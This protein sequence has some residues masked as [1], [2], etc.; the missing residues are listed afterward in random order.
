M[1]LEKNKHQLQY[2][3]GLALSLDPAL[4]PEG[5]S[6]DLYNVYLYKGTIK[7]SPGYRYF[8]EQDTALASDL[9]EPILHLAPYYE[10]EEFQYHLVFT[11]TGLYQLTDVEY[12]VLDNTVAYDDVY[13]ITT[14]RWLN[15]TFIATLAED[16]SYW[17]ADGTGVVTP[18][19]LID[20]QAR[21]VLNHYSHLVLGYLT[22][23]SVVSRTRIKWSKVGDPTDFTSVTSGFVDL[24][25]TP[26]EVVALASIQD[27]LI[28]MKS[29]A[30][31][32]G[33]YVG[34]NDTFKFSL[35]ASTQ[36]CL[37]TNSVV[38]VKNTLFFLGKDNIYRF[39][40]REFQPIGDPIKREFFGPGVTVSK[41]NLKYCQATYVPQTEQ[42]WFAIPSGSFWAFDIYIYDIDT[43]SWWH[44]F[45]EGG[46]RSLVA[47]DRVDFIQWNEMPQPWEEETRSWNSID[48]SQ[49]RAEI[50]SGNDTSVMSFTLDLGSDLGVYPNAHWATK[51]LTIGWRTRWFAVAAEVMG[52]EG[53]TCYYS[54]DEGSTWT[55][56]GLQAPSG[57]KGFEKCHWP[58]NVSAETMRF[59]FVLGDGDVRMKNLVAYYRD[60]KGER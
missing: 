11:A 57:T 17:E 27:R 34:G 46:T 35:L 59:K 50:L 8:P 55:S 21:C 30:I 40:G 4:L 7:R 20:V 28:V 33:I 22:E 14:S 45:F 18:A 60:R 49:A 15:K 19:D 25:D 23:S 47:Y 6:P 53:V 1:F 31:Y 41:F 36:G 10:D 13:D 39:D 12:T 38:D 32:E 51:D 24:I 3:H 56:L 9:G 29:D 43:N 52:T 44:K 42:V 16:V 37:A 48:L 26:G 5:A 54:E 58:M 2:K